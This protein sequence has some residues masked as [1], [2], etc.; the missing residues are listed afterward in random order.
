MAKLGIH[1]TGIVL[2]FFAGCSGRRIS[3]QVAAPVKQ[4]NQGTGELVGQL[5]AKLYDVPVPFHEAPGKLLSDF[6]DAPDTIV[7]SYTTRMLKPQLIEL[8]QQEMER[9]GWQEMAYFNADDSLLVFKKP[10]RWTSVLI[11]DPE[12]DQCEL[13]LFT[14]IKANPSV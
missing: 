1:L 8:Y 12:L 10:Q 2:L 7:I 4:H 11:K 3:K 5:E 6:N 14:G 9:F 13:V